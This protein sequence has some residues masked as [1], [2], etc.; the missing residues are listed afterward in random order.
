MGA[1]SPS[2]RRR[3]VDKCRDKS[4]QTIRHELRYARPAVL[5]STG[6]LRA[7][8]NPLSPTTRFCPRL[9][10]PLPLTVSAPG[11]RHTDAR[12]PDPPP[13]P[14]RVPLLSLPDHLSP[15][16][17]LYRFTLPVQ[18]SDPTTSSLAALLSLIRSIPFRSIPFR[19]Y[20]PHL[21]TLGNEQPPSKT[22]SVTRPTII[23]RTWLVD[24]Y[25]INSRPFPLPLFSVSYLLL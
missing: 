22:G 25:P 14:P 8:W 2:R 23:L 9:R 17:P 19:C 1:R 6:A 12:S 10:H 24:A 3:Q 7:S 4:A 21:E 11:L 13:L 16:S 5:P 20:D 18:P 15:L